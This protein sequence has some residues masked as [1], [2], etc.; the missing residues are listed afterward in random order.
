VEISRTSNERLKLPPVVTYVTRLPIPSSPSGTSLSF[1]NQSSTV[2]GGDRR[3]S[4][5]VTSAW[6][7]S[8]QPVVRGLDDGAAAAS[9]AAV[10]EV[11]PEADGAPAADD[12]EGD[13]SMKPPSQRRPSGIRSTLSCSQ[14]L[15]GPNDRHR[16]ALVT[17]SSNPALMQRNGGGDDRQR[18][19][20]APVSSARDVI[21]D[22][23]HVTVDVIVVYSCRLNHV[24]G[25]VIVPV[26]RR[27]RRPVTSSPAG[28]T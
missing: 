13:G 20:P 5:V 15:G 19:G 12:G 28:V 8:P 10:G 4:S 2:T 7:P 26:R 17:V 11:P 14:L 9:A 6:A 16:P 24:I 18:D 1:L 23:R 22:R 27:S 21:A 25:D 3:S